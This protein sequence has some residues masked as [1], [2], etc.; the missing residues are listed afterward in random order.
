[1]PKK[2]IRK[3]GGGKVE[4]EV[5]NSGFRSVFNAEKEKRLEWLWITDGPV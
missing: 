5:E 1:M 2:K 3:T 4:K